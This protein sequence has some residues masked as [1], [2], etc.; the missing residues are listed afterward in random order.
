M[1]SFLFARGF[2]SG[3][4][5]IVVFSVTPRF[6]FD[7]CRC[8][9]VDLPAFPFL[10]VWLSLETVFVNGRTIS[11]NTIFLDWPSGNLEHY[12]T[13]LEP[14]ILA[15]EPESEAGAF[16]PE[17]AAFEPE[18]LSLILSSSCIIGVFITCHVLFCLINECL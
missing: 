7:W 18:A 2:L 14:E 15:F 8:V 3:C 10:P 6:F 12:A 17:A 9:Y 13:G 16:D 5:L 4:L 1:T 11:G